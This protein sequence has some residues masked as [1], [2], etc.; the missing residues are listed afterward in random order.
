MLKHRRSPHLLQ[1][2]VSAVERFCQAGR[3][4]G[5]VRGEHGVKLAPRAAEPWASGWEVDAAGPL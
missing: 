1:G 5:L 4:E 3:A 2:T